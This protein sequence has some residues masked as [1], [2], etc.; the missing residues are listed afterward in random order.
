MADVNQL[1][2]QFGTLFWLI[3]LLG[4]VWFLVKGMDE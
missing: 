3:L 1:V 4:F 2:L